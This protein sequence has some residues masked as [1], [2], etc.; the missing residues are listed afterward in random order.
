MLRPCLRSGKCGDE[1]EFV[2]ID[3]MKLDHVT[4]E[5]PPN[6]ENFEAE[7]RDIKLTG[8]GDFLIEEIE[9]DLSNESRIKIHLKIPRLNAEGQY[10]S[11]FNV[12]WFSPTLKGRFVGEIMDLTM[13]L[14]MYGEHEIREEKTFIKF[15]DSEI[16]ATID[17]MKVQVKNKFPYQIFN[18]LMNSYINQNTKLVIPVAETLV[19]KTLGEL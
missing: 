13:R 10:E 9:V 18:G 15:T 3:P 8:A 1:L 11:T 12:G 4:V 2:G 5:Q 7:L 14:V 16:I 17:D 6:L 19:E